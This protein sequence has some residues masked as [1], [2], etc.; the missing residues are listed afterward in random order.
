MEGVSFIDTLA[1]AG[2][3]D[4]HT[5]QYYEMFGCRALYHEGWKAVTYHPIQATQPGLDEAVWE[6]YDLRADPTECH[7]LAA[8]EPERLKEMVDRWWEEAERYDVL[9]VDNRPLSEFVEHRPKGVPPRERYVYRPHRAP[10]PELVAANVKRRPHEVVAS[11]DVP[12]GG[13]EG[14][15]I[16]QGT[17]LGG[18]GLYLLDGRLRYVHNGSGKDPCHVG[19][20]DPIPPGRHTAGMRYTPGERQPGIVE[21]RID[22]EVVASAPVP[23]FTWHRFSLTGAGLTAG[24]ALAP[25]VSDEFTAPFP[26]TG[27]IHDVVVTVDG[28]PK[29]DPIAEILDALASQ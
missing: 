13:A 29:H 21:L 5:T 28:D 14:V 3:T 8:A 12:D 24:R 9:P 7:D 20:P 16:A 1:D 22:D 4:R 19:A 11:I 27:T 18:W 15:L 25:A 23:D 17:V 6:L 26:F 10:V 2:A